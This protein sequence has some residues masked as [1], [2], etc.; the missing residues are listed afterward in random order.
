MEYP[1]WLNQELW[2]EY[3]R[4]R[5][6]I[7]KPMTP[8]AEKLNIDKLNKIM[9]QGYTQKK[10]MENVLEL[11]WQGIYAPVERNY[12]RPKAEAAPIPRNPIRDPKQE[13]LAVEE[14]QRRLA[15]LG[16]NYSK[17][18]NKDMYPT[19][20]EWEKSQRLLGH[21]ADGCFKEMP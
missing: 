21:L 4:H 17:P 12:N 8:F 18:I 9:K 20:V 3:K 5:V 19:R 11:G 13:A 15:K 7:R 6:R 16:N 1:D 10:I 2:N 14:T